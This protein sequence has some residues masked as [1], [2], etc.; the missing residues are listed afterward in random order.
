MAL[1]AGSSVDAC[2][3]SEN[4][5]SLGGAID[6]GTGIYGTSPIEVRDSLFEGNAARTVGGA[7]RNPY[8]DDGLSINVY[9]CEFVGNS[10]DGAFGAVYGAELIADSTFENNSARS[11]GGAVHTAGSVENCE[12]IGNYAGFSGGAL[13]TAGSATGC[14]FTGNEAGTEGGAIYS[15]EFV[16]GCEFVGNI[17]T[18]D[19]GGVYEVPVLLRSS[20]S[21]NTARYGGGAFNPVDVESCLFFQNDGRLGGGGV[22]LNGNQE[23]LIQSSVFI[24]N[25]NEDGKDGAD[26]YSASTELTIS[27]STF[28][29]TTPN[30][31]AML[32]VENQDTWIESSVIWDE[33]WNESKVISLGDNAPTVF[34]YSD[35]RVDSVSLAA[36]EQSDV[37]LLGGNISGNPRFADASAGDVRLLPGSPCIDA[38]FS[39]GSQGPDG[40]DV[41]GESREPFDDPGVI[42]IGLGAGGYL[43]IGAVESRGASCLADVNGDGDLTPTDFSAW[44]GAYQRGDA[45]ADQNRDGVLTPT[46]FSAWVNNYTNGC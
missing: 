10:S 34:V 43:D 36:I 41:Y 7:I 29:R 5:A 38:G 42:N 26:L 30:I 2:Y 19:G 16:D 4:T 40:V 12:F 27:S 45:I 9:G 15:A 37:Y 31:N 32:F 25:T 20:F 3:L 44:V 33:S 21:G 1:R 6:I 8:Y 22:W 28:A 39:F 24:D 35:L 11:E 18:L 17:A 46:D 14:V 23:T 13:H